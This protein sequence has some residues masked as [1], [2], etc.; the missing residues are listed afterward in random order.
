MEALTECYTNGTYTKVPEFLGFRRREASS[1]TFLE[2]DCEHGLLLLRHALME[3]LSS[4]YKVQQVAEGLVQRV[5][6]IVQEDM[7]CFR[8]DSAG[9]STVN[10]DL[11]QLP[12]WLPPLS[13][14]RCATSLL[15]CAAIAGPAVVR[16]L[17]RCS[18]TDSWHPEVQRHPRAIIQ[19][20]KRRLPVQCA[21]CAG[22]VAGSS[23]GKP[24]SRC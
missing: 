20:R 15:H 10:E 13:C 9:D 4:S 14:T 21:W 11:S 2:A 8:T 5:A 17:Q 18:S 6:A 12:Q 16:G 24:Y 23:P 19:A 1:R 22:V 3:G 7:E